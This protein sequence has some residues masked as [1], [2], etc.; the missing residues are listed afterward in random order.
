[1]SALNLSDSSELSSV[2]DCGSSSGEASESNPELQFLPLEKAKSAVRDYFGFPAEN[3][4][5]K[6][7]EKRKR[8]EV[9]C[10]LCPKRIQYQGSTTNMLV[11][12]QYNHRQEYSKVKSKGSQAKVAE[13]R[14]PLITES[15][16]HL[17][18]FSQHSAKWK[19]LTKSVCQYI[20][21]D[22]MPFSTVNN[23]G[24]RNMLHTF[25]PRYVLPD[26]KAIT[27][28]YIPEM[29]ECE[30]RKIMNAMEHGLEYCALTTDGWTSHATQSYVTHT[31]HYINKTWNL[32]SHLLE[33][34]ELPV[35][36]SAINLADELK[37]SLSRWK[38]QDDQIVAATTD[39][40]RNMVNA[41]E[42]LS[43]QHFGCFAHT[44]QLGVKKC[45][46]VPQV[47]KA[48]GRARRLVSHFH[49]S[50][51]SSYVLKQKQND[52]HVDKLK[53]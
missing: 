28:H 47:S 38:L 36:H 37:E 31:V 11:H 12:L 21:K 8:T 16:Q 2:S 53:T 35:A 30:K 50:S 7:K 13:Q 3:G 23:E 44:L 34:T 52:L 49:H 24:F 25:E 40:A 41:L 45:L 14:Q 33:T 48:L 26:R 22:M 27:N 6:E 42:V 51:K 19:S 15:I 1:M 29:Y 43:W 17:Q 9:H 32:C 46:E 39:N 10:K 4:Q 20:A 5:F 18:P